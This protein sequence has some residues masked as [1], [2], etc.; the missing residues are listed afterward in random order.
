LRASRHRRARRAT[1]DGQGVRRVLRSALSLWQRTFTKGIDEYQNAYSTKVGSH[2]IHCG[3]QIAADIRLT[4][5]RSN[6]SLLA[7]R[8]IS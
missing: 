2:W 4:T 7:H 3:F 5:S 1:A 6:T 8:L